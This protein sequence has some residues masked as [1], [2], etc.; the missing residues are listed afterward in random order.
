MVFAPL[1]RTPESDMDDTLKTDT[2]IRDRIDLTR[3]D[4]VRYW[5]KRLGVTR[6]RLAAAMGAVGARAGAVEA[7]LHL[8][9]ARRR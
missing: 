2:P 9:G 7:Y 4:E 6:N 1:T 5:T 3:D 8:R